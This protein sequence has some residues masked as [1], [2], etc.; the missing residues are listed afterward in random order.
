MRLLLQNKSWTAMVILSLALGIG[1]NTAI[2]SAVN[3]LVLQT[4]PGTR[5]LD[6]CRKRIAQPT[7]TRTAPEC[8]SS[9][10]R[11]AA[12]ACTTRAPTRIGR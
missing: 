4:L 3:G 7:G 11:T 6:P 1:A 12:A 5:S 2:F 8:P 9:E 10:R